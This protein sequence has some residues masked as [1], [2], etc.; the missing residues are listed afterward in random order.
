MTDGLRGQGYVDAELPQAKPRKAPSFLTL[1]RAIFRFLRHE[2]FPGARLRWKRTGPIPAL[3]AIGPVLHVFDDA[4]TRA[5]NLRARQAGL[6]PT[7][8][9][10]HALAAAAREA[11]LESAVITRWHIPV[12]IRGKSAGSETLSNQLTNFVQEIA[13]GEDAAS[14]QQRQFRQLRDGDPYANWFFLNLGDVPGL[15]RTLDGKVKGQYRRPARSERVT[16]TFSS[17]GPWPAAGAPDKMG[18]ETVVPYGNV[19]LKNP[20]CLVN[21]VW[22]GRW[23]FGLQAH[24][25]ICTSTAELERVR[26]RIVERV[27]EGAKS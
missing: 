1:L 25:S 4:E 22:R 21:M 12:S 5:L 7:N 10:L 27:R 17:L 24:T 16:G 14:I 26:D 15:G 18:G 11:W 2:I 19:S 20:I 8:W 23:T 13:D 9:L 3:G 6:L